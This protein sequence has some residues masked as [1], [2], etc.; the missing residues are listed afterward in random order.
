MT[1]RP[2]RPDEVDGVDYHFV[3]RE[4]FEAAVAAGELVEWA[5][6]SGHLYGTPR[7][8]IESPLA[9]GE[10]VLLDI[11]IMGARQV[12]EAFPDAVMVY[13]LPPSLKALEERLRQRGDTNEEAMQERLAVAEWQIQ[14]AQDL[15]DYFVENDD[16]DQAVEAAAGILAAPRPP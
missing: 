14:Q 4:E 12:K 6:Y 10:D 2:A 3:S 1:T 16:L 13:V 15:F 9:A 11:E 5:R 7:A 8:E